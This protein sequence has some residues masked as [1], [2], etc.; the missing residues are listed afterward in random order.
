MT[1]TSQYHNVTVTLP[2]GMFRT[3]QWHLMVYCGL[4]A[5]AITGLIEAKDVV[6][7]CSRIGEVY[8]LPYQVCMLLLARPS[9]IIR[10]MIYP[11]LLLR[12]L[13]FVL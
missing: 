5:C 8:K 11:Y 12:K 1:S 2:Q 9:N 3:S 10:Y 4:F 13:L 7:T 6:D